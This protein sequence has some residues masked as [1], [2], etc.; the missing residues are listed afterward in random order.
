MYVCTNVHVYACMYRM[1]L[2]RYVRVCTYMYVYVCVL[3]I[4]VC[5]YVYI[6]IYIYIYIYTD[7]QTRIQ[8]LSCTQEEHI[9]IL[10]WRC[11]THRGLL[12]SC[13]Y[14]CVHMRTYTKHTNITVRGHTHVRTCSTLKQCI[15]QGQ[16]ISYLHVCTYVCL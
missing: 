10:A 12:V 5:I 16:Y 1:L 3:Y 13:T 11:D 15:M 4:Y 8:I 14:A 2:Y 7:K 6:Y 9:C